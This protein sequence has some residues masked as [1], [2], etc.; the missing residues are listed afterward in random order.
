MDAYFGSLIVE[1]G[2]SDEF[3]SESKSHR[4]AGRLEVKHLAHIAISNWRL[5][6]DGPLGN[7]LEERS[8]NAIFFQTFA[9]T[10]F[11]TRS[12]A[13]VLTYAL[14][15]LLPLIMIYHRLY[16]GNQSWPFNLIV[17]C[18]TV[19]NETEQL[20]K[21]QPRSDLLVLKSGLPRLLVQVS[22]KSSKDWNTTPEDH[23]RM[24]LM[25]AA[26]VRFANKFS[27]RFMET[28]NFVLCATYIWFNSKVS[29]YLLYQ[30]PDKPEVCR[31]SY[32]YACGLSRRRFIAEDLLI[33]CTPQL[34]APNLYANCTTF[35]TCWK[36]RKLTTP[37]KR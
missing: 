23:T 30:G 24:L 28:K 33:R 18:E 6:W 35:A 34:G 31:A 36:L 10:T 8:M 29:R 27:P 14:T 25:G 4:R 9:L 17:K 20:C 3:T 15:C 2:S 22:S 11:E 1:D 32:Y 37:P 26:V 19:S 12:T 5:L 21:F 16:R 13:T 7:T